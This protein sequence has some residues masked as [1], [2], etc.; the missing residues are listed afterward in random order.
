MPRPRKVS[1]EEMIQSMAALTGSRLREIRRELIW[2]ALSPETQA[3]YASEIRFQQEVAA[4]AGD[5]HLS[6]EYIEKF[7][8][9][10]VFEKKEEHSRVLRAKAAWSCMAAMEGVEYPQSTADRLNSLG[11]VGP[12]G[13]TGWEKLCEVIEWLHQQDKEF[14]GFYAAGLLLIFKGKLRHAQLKA[15][16]ISDV[17]LC[18]D[19]SARLLIR[20][21]QK[22]KGSRFSKKEKAKRA[23]SKTVMGDE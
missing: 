22:A 21:A 18:P 19:G 4:G 10:L 9:V 14:G 1:A 2:K 8:C 16:R 7:L 17:Q 15:L 11:E 13:S 6:T 5:T 12:R 3:Q 20:T 23:V